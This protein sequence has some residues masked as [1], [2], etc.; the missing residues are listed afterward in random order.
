MIRDALGSLDKVT[1]VV[2]VLGMVNV[3]PGFNQTPDVMNGFSELFFDVFGPEAGP[4][5]RSAIGVAE[6]PADFPVE[7]EVILEV[8]D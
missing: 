6:L 8:G 7:I 1:R 2:K 4:H 5:A 3:A